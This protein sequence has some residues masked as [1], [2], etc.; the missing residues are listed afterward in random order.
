MICT[1]WRGSVIEKDFRCNICGEQIAD[2]YGK[3]IG[4]AAV[5]PKGGEILQCPS[6]RNVV[7]HFMEIEVRTE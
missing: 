5:T 2:Q 3:L 1:I 6:C 7:A 4:R